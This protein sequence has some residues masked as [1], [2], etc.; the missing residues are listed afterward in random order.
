MQT[1]AA[2]MEIGMKGLK[3]PESIINPVLPTTLSNIPKGL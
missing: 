2:N 3:K 1:D